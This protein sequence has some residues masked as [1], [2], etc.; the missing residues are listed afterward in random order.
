MY[1]GWKQTDYKK[2]LH[3]V[4]YMDKTDNQM[5][6]QNIQRMDKNKLPNMATKFTENGH[7]LTTKFGYKM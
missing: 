2:W 7:K 3:H 6:L 5:W 4:Q 1:R